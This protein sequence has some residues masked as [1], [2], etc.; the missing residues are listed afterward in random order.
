MEPPPIYDQVYYR[1]EERAN[2]VTTNADLVAN[3]VTTEIVAAE[4]RRRGEL[5]EW[6]R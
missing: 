6:G 4:V 1:Q 5:W 2:Y 3:G